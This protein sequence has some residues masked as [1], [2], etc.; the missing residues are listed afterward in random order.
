M[1]EKDITI[2]TDKYY[3]Q[4][5]RIIGYFGWNIM[6]IKVNEGDTILIYSPED[7][8]YNMIYS[9]DNVLRE[10][11]TLVKGYNIVKVDPGYRYIGV[12]N[13]ASK[14]EKVKIYRL[15]KGDISNIFNKIEATDTGGYLF[16]HQLFTYVDE[17]SGLEKYSPT[18]NASDFIDVSNYSTI[19]VQSPKS[20]IYN[21]FYDIDKKY[22]SNFNYEAGL[23]YIT[24]PDNAKYIRISNESKM[25]TETKIWF[26]TSFLSK[27]HEYVGALLPMCNDKFWEH[28]REKYI[29]EA[30]NNLLTKYKSNPDIIP[31]FVCTDSHRWSPQHPQRYV[32]N[33]DVDGI[34]ITNINLGDVV[35]Q[36]WADG[37]FDMINNS[38]KFIKNYI[39]V[40][41]NHDKMDGTVTTDYFARRIFRT[42]NYDAKFIKGCTRC[43]YSVKVPKHSVKYIVFDPYFIPNSESPIISIPSMIGSW[44]INE[45]SSDDEYDIV[46]LNHQP[47]TDNNIH[48]DGTKQS[49]K[50]DDIEAPICKSLFSLLKDRKNKRKGNYTDTD[51]VVHPYDFTSCKNELLCLLHGHAHEELYYKEDNLL[52]YCCDWDGAE[53]GGYKCTFIAIDRTNKIFTSWIANNTSRVEDAFTLNI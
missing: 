49:W 28:E 24:K 53:P 5:K 40:V 10:N 37:K 48:R 9:N 3:T 26:D 31:I 51:N 33:I 7:S 22:I 47:L 2:E 14:L 18:Y 35:Q 6:H 36:Y 42:T 1:T 29:S 12:S 13:E 30:Y 34:E 17:K 16:T 8:P 50:M 11:Y 15:S 43:C 45:L 52:S 32:N 4:D 39:G 27:D 20:S 21:V 46:F 19:Y 38:I 41:G 44:L 25:L 23:T